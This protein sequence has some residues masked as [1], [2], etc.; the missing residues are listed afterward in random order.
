MT[1]IF[2]D[3]SGRT[4]PGLDGQPTTRLRGEQFVLRHPETRRLASLS[5]AAD[6]DFLAL[7][8]MTAMHVAGLLGMP[9][10]RVTDLRLAVDEA[11]SLFLAPLPHKPAPGSAH[12]RLTLQFDHTGEAL[13][14]RVSGPAPEQG[15][16]Q[17]DLGWTMLCALVGEP[18][19]EARDGIGILTLTEP[20]PTARR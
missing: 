12:D 5:F 19:W 9:I 15:P 11:C 17:D 16:D 13:R 1:G 6:R 3:E 4:A 20:I 2:L 7:A 14:I 18:R 10:G 8:R